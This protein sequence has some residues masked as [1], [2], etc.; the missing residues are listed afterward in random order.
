MIMLEPS[1]YNSQAM[2]KALE[3]H[4]LRYLMK[5]NTYRKNLLNNCFDLLFQST[6]AQAL[7]S[8]FGGDYASKQTFNRNWRFLITRR[9]CHWWRLST[10]ISTQFSTQFSTGLAVVEGC[11]DYNVWWNGRGVRNNDYW[12]PP[13]PPSYE[14]V[15]P[16]N[17]RAVQNESMS[18]F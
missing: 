13:P 6:Y 11:L 15:L 16:S 5:L 1:N 9:R 18:K 10:Q 17:G 7:S 14:I 2:E 12:T 3:I 4:F 8:A